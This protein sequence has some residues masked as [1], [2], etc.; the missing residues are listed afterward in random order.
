MTG[1]PLIVF[2][3]KTVANE[4]FIQNQTT[5]ANQLLGLM[6]VNSVFIPFVRISLHG[7]IRDGSRVKNYKTSRQGKIEFA[8]T[9][10]GRDRE[11]EVI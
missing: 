3:R 8:S 9:S 1:G 5:F 7:C 11:V 6:P 10:T 4:T 2:T